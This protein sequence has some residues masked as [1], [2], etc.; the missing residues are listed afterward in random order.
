[1]LANDADPQRPAAHGQPRRRP[2]PR[3][4]GAQPRR[5]VHLH[6]D[7]QLLRQRHVH[8][9]RHRRPVFQ[10]LR[11]RHDHRHYVNHP[12]VVTDDAYTLAQGSTLTT[13]QATSSIVGTSGN[14]FNYGP[15]DGAYSAYLQ[16]G[17]GATVRFVP[18][19]NPG[20]DYSFTFSAP[21]RG[22]LTPGTYA[23]ATR[24]PFQAAGTPG[25][26]IT[27]G[28]YGSN[29]MTGQF[30]IYD[31]QYDAA[32]N[33]SAPVGRLHGLPRQRRHALGRARPVP[34]RQ[35]P[36]HRR[37]HQRRRPRQPPPRRG[38][39]QRPV[40]RRPDAA[41][42]R[43]VR[44]HALPDLLRDRRLHLQGELRH[45]QLEPRHGHA[46]RGTSPPARPT[47]RLQAA[48]NGTL[49]VAAPA[50][51]WRR[52]R[53]RRRRG[54]GL[55][56]LGAVPRVADAEPRRV[57]TRPGRRLPRPR[58]LHLPGGRRHPQL[59]AATVDPVN[60]APTASDWSVATHSLQPV[61]VPLAAGDLDNDP[62]TYT[63]VGGPSHGTLSGT[64]PNLTYTPSPGFSG[65]DSITF[66]V[67]DAASTATATVSICA[68]KIDPTI[69]WSNPA[70]IVYGGLGAATERDGLD[71]GHLGLHHPGRQRPE[72]G[73]RSGAPGHLHARRHR[74]LQ[75]GH[76]L[77]LDQRAQGPPDRDGRAEVQG[78]RR[79]PAGADVHAERVGQRRHGGGRLGQLVPLDRGDRGERG[80]LVP[81]RDRGRHALRGELRLPLPRRLRVSITKA[82]L[83]ITV[84]GKEM[85]HGDP[86]PALTC[87]VAGL[88]NGD[89][90]SALAG[91]P[92][93]STM[94]TSTSAAGTYPIAIGAGTLSAANY[95]FTF[96]PAGSL[97]VHPKV[98]DVRVRYG[99][100]SISLLGITRDLPFLNI[101]A[102]DVIF[103]DDVT[104]GSGNLSLKSTA[105][106]SHYAFGGF[107]YN[108]ATRDATWRL[109]AAWGWTA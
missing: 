98:L 39:G 79:V 35:R 97:T 20:N 30:T 14:V 7:R 21:D 103:S 94:A 61:A 90:A 68:H 85:G 1:M 93:L 8:L 88:V 82:R 22:H 81:D 45:P 73:G 58:R 70:E 11:R 53:P 99:S 23:N 89:T 96:G 102:V 63:I 67:N 46:Q 60:A 26:W 31:A 29:T 101:T 32:G 13:A 92:A 10:R 91:A 33:L 5:L 80:R 43:I 84:N 3:H 17:Y 59:N 9:P 66:R 49:T 42:R 75:F 55:G 62:L 83:T 64:A 37:P 16:Y 57:V 105:S 107:S 77:G 2:E 104:I 65:W 4:A 15:N 76:R 24:F 47:Q 40:P 51:S 38:P 108:A 106:G 18:T 19:A 71:P 109:P 28:S 48:A 86:V 25:F 56:G 72:R 95:D 50:A 12:P 36:A 69:N 87:S 78:L 74:R 44:L 6:A 52:R 54:D 100:R 27:V 41:R 34:L